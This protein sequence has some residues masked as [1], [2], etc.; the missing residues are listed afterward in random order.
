MLTEHIEGRCLAHR[1]FIDQTI[2]VLAFEELVLG[3]DLRQDFEVA[4][5]QILRLREFRLFGGLLL[6]IVS[7]APLMA[8]I[9]VLTTVGGKDLETITVVIIIN[10]FS[11]LHFFILRICL[12]GVDHSGH[13]F[14][15]L[16]VRRLRLL[17]QFLLC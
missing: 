1:H 4:D 5:M 17:F 7:L 6:V 11:T 2:A 13:R 9:A 15:N 12:C 3:I 10:L 16:F 14:L 8:T